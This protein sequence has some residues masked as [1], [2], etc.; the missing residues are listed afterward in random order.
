MKSKW[1]FLTCVFLIS[2]FINGQIPNTLTMND[3]MY[4]LSKF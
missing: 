1:M 3:K 2:N 4:G